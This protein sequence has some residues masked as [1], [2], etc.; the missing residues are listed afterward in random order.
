MLDRD[1]YSVWALLL[2]I[3][4]Y[5]GLVNFGLQTA[6]G[7]F[8][9]HT[10][11]RNDVI[12]RNQIVSTAVALLSGSAVISIFAI[13]ALSGMLP[14][15]FPAIPASLLA[16]AKIAL[17]L[18]GSSLALGLPFSVLNGVFVGLQRNEIPAMIIIV[19]RL[20]TALGLVLAAAWGKGLVVM[21]AIFGGINILSY[22]ALLF[23]IK[24]YVPNLLISKQLV[25]SQSFRE[26]MDY[27]TSLSVWNF[28]MLLVSG[29][30]LVLVARFDFSAVGG[31][32]I[33]SSLLTLLVGAQ[34][35]ILSVILPAGAALDAQGDRKRLMGLLLN[36]T[37]WN[38]LLLGIITGLYCVL[39]PILLNGYVGHDYAS[40]ISP[41][42]SVLLLATVIRLSM[43]PFNLLAMGAGDHRRIIL[44]PLAEGFSN[45]LASTFLGW[46]FGAIGV[47]WGTVLGG[48]VGVAFHLG[49][50]LPR[51]SR[52]GVSLQVFT[53]QAFSPG[54]IAVLP[55]LLLLV[56]E[57]AAVR[58]F[59]EHVWESPVM[60]GVMFGAFAWKMLLLPNEREYVLS[61]IGVVYP[62]RH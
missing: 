56:L 19:G 26:L 5:T 54:I 33:A 36:T 24:H 48:A 9:A 60:A 50:N 58:L 18:V 40:K 1:T 29:L 4:G 17:I 38:L 2:Q 13:F 12:Q 30:D 6:V 32:A 37:R 25:N 11:A 57:G 43:L 35:A 23:A 20:S 14:L 46:K 44:G 21:G 39:K 28:A 45:I 47:A 62:R 52:L 10:D 53:T 61:K 27:C 55:L 3:G 16:N 59:G 31:F 34:S 41:I 15:F 7:R 22:S 8:T 49:L 42:L 51:S